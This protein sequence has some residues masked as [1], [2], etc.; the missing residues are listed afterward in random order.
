MGRVGGA[1]EVDR[2]LQAA[3]LGRVVGGQERGWGA[4]ADGF[5]AADSGGVGAGEGR[6]GAF[7][8]AVYELDPRRYDRSGLAWLLGAKGLVRGLTVLLLAG[9]REARY[10]FL[11]ASVPRV[12]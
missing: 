3:G 4:G 12:S 5:E 7:A 11:A 9:P 10:L 6:V 8:L 2:G 1:A